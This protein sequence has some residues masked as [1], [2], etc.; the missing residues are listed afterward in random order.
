MKDTALIQHVYPGLGME[1]FLDLVYKRHSIYCDVHSI[2]YRALITRP[3]AG[4]D[5]NNGHWEMVH[6]IDDALKQ[7]YKKAVWL[8]ADAYIANLDADLRDA[9]PEDGP[10]AVL[11][12]SPPCVYEHYNSGAM[13]FGNGERCSRFM[14]LWLEWSNK[15]NEQVYLN[16]LARTFVTELP[17]QWNYT[18][19]RHNGNTKPIIR[20]F[21]GVKSLDDRFKLMRSSLK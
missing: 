21:H 9:C 1:K 19:Q 20:A 17:C 14:Q 7:G 13:Y 5:L 15:I 2:D 3:R 8:D 10:A 16:V 12:P 18:Y 4:L 11:F 6:L